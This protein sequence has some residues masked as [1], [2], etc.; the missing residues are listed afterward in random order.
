MECTHS[1]MCEYCE[2]EI[3]WAVKKHLAENLWREWKKCNK[4]TDTITLQNRV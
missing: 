3:K 2:M 4:K 1:P